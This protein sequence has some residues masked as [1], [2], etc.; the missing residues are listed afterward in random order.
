MSQEILVDEMLVVAKAC[1]RDDL[2]HLPQSVELPELDEIIS[3]T[4]T[5]KPG[6]HVYED[7]GSHSAIDILA[8]IAMREIVRQGAVWIVTHAGEFVESPGRTALTVLH[9]TMRRTNTDQRSVS[10]LGH[11]N[12]SAKPDH[13][14]LQEVINITANAGDGLDH[15]LVIIESVPTLFEHAMVDTRQAM[16]FIE[17]LDQVAASYGKTVL[18]NTDFRLT[19]DFPQIRTKIGVQRTGN[20]CVIGDNTRPFPVWDNVMVSRLFPTAPEGALPSRTI[21]IPRLHTLTI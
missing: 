16:C 17:K 3:D 19:L 11:V 21:L 1:G 7:D 12:I 8:Y 5:R 13:D 9:N 14:L 6:I 10:R 15:K 18:L 20:G 4:L 2:Q